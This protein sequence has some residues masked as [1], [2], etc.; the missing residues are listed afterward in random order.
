M[1][2]AAFMSLSW[3]AL[4]PVFI[5]LCIVYF[6]RDLIS[7]VYNQTNMTQV[8]ICNIQAFLSLNGL[9]L[10]TDSRKESIRAYVQNKDKARCLV[11]GLLLRQ[12]CGVTEDSQLVYG[13][14]GKPYLKNSTMY[15]NISHSGDYVVLAI[16]NRE[17]GI[18]IENIERKAP[19]SSKVAARC[20]TK[21]ECEWMGEGDN[22]PFFRL[23][24]A[25]ESI[26][27]ASGF[28][29]SLP[30]ES[31]CVLPM[32]GSAHYIVGKNWFLEWILYDDYI[33]CLAIEREADKSEIITIMP[34]ELLIA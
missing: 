33:I 27:K 12:I 17:I 31:F 15:F 30:P 3:F 29:F 24:T 18:D 22:E 1:F 10:V 11:S 16:S 5:G 14:N 7:A 19:Y 23:W 6:A 8:Y 13:N 4:L 9:N 20:F 21:Q 28:G 2:A 25:K 26:M 32:D 34:D